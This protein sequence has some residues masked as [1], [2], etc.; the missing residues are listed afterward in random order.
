MGDLNAKSTLWGADK[1]NENGDILDNLIL[2]NDYIIV[3][4][5]EPTHVHFN[6][7]TSSILDYCI[8]TTKLYDIFKEYL[9]LKE[10]DMTSDHFPSLI[11][12]KINENKQNNNSRQ[13]FYKTKQF[14]YNKANWELFRRSLPNRL[15]SN[16]G[17]SVDEINEFVRNSLINAADCSIPIFKNNN[18]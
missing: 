11:K 3:N 2:E 7:K 1:N 12:L 13:Y 17:T 6:G 5:K 10:E 4:N 9:L 15:D 18:S 8:I 14:N 16:S